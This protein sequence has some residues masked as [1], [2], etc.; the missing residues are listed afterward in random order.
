MGTA[1]HDGPAKPKVE[2][3]MKYMLL[4]YS[5]EANMQSAS[6][7][8]GEQMMAAYRAYTEAMRKAGVYRRR[9]APASHDGGEHRACR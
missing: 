9:R 6:K 2:G 1:E 7:A 8:D 5:N 3:T 4:I